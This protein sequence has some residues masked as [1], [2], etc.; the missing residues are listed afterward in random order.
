MAGIRQLA[1][2]LEL[3]IGT[4]SRALNDR[5]DV[6]PDTRARVKAAA[7]RAGYVPNQ[8]GRSLRSGRTGMVAAVIPTRAPSADSGLLTV[9][10]GVRRT[11]RAHNLDL[12]LLFRGPEEDPLE[13][14]QRIVQRRIADS[15]VISETTAR[16]PRLAYLQAAGVEYVAF[17]RS[18]GMEDYPFV[19]FDVEAVAAETA[20]LFVRDG[21]RRLALVGNPELLNYETLILEAFVGEAVR[22]GLPRDAVRLILTDAGHLTQ[23]DLRLLADPDGPTALLA[24]HESLAAGL[25]VDLGEIGLVVGRDVSVVCTFPAVDTRGIVP[26]LSHFQADLDAVGVALARHIVT[27]LPESDEVPSA[28]TLVPLRFAPRASHG[29]A[30]LQVQRV[31]QAPLRDDERTQASTK[32]TPVTPSSI[33]G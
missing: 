6:N 27:R 9:L 15:I 17:G 23:S 30:A 26:A 7:M 25:Y 19:D 1:N 12:I 8:S 11:L 22:L 13:S 14:L 21:H 31:T 24:T 33:V 16:D 2:E 20:R 10:E 28:S 3:S 18:A 4:V 29:R 32:A 5:P